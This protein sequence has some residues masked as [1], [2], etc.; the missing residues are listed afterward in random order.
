MNV[1]PKLIADIRFFESSSRTEFGSINH[2]SLGTLYPIPFRSFGAIGDRFACKLREYKFKLPGFDHLYIILS[3]SLPDG[4]AEPSTLDIDKRIRYVDFVQS[5]HAWQT[6][7]E[8]SKHDLLIEFAAV[9]LRLHSEDHGILDSVVQE[10]KS[11]RSELE[12]VVKSKETRSYRVEVSYQ[13]RPLQKQSVAFLSY[14]DKTSGQSGKVELAKLFTANDV[15]P[16]CGSI[17][18]ANGTISIKPRPSFR[19]TILTNKYD[20][21]MSFAVETV[22]GHK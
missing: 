14:L 4:A 5:P 13:I 12:I 16:L 22:I 6:L 18:V 9:A 7:T 17:S 19:A 1:K 21:P 15:Y 10:L 20:L 8:D 2:G 3:S 11:H